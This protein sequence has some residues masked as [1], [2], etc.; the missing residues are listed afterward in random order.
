MACILSAMLC[1]YSEDDHSDPI[2]ELICFQCQPCQSYPWHSELKTS[3]LTT[4]QRNVMLSRC[5]QA[6]VLSGILNK[7]FSSY[8]IHVDR[9]YWYFSDLYGTIHVYSTS[10]L[11]WLHTCTVKPRPVDTPPMWTPCSC[12]H[13]SQGPLSI[14]YYSSAAKILKLVDTTVDNSL[15][16]TLFVRPL[17]VQWG[18]TVC[19]TWDTVG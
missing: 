7:L 13:F 4:R 6:S 5:V 9:R 17:R 1:R 10:W 18:S 11:G 2:F 16:G 19:T 15:M 8:Y 3:H 14:P 12:G